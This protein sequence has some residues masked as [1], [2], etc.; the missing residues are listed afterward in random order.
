MAHTMNLHHWYTMNLTA[1]EGAL[2]ALWEQQNQWQQQS[3]R[4]VEQLQ[5]QNLRMFEQLDKMNQRMLTQMLDL[6]REWVDEEDEVSKD[7][8]C[9]EHHP[10][11]DASLVLDEIPKKNSHAMSETELPATF[12]VVSSDCGSLL[13]ANSSEKRLD[14]VAE[15]CLPFHELE[16]SGCEDSYDGMKVIR[17]HC[18]VWQEMTLRAHRMEGGWLADLLY[19]SK[20]K[21]LKL[22]S[23]EN[24][25]WKWAKSSSFVAFDPGGMLFCFKQTVDTS[26]NVLKEGGMDVGLTPQAISVLGGYR[27]QGRNVCGAV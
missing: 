9:A 6:L 19:C 12:A 23:C 15:Q 21:T 20:F 17:Q 18:E 16:L 3:L 22:L 26:V 2:V 7:Y 1:M 4:F 13:L 24:H 8:G 14:F 10:L 5:Q 27:P 11:A 25:G